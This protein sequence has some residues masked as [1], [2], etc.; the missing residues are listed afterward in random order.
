AR[1]AA[2]DAKP[3]VQAWNNGSRDAVSSV[4]RSFGTVRSLVVGAYAEASD[5]LH[6]LFDCVV[7]SASK[8]H[9]RR[10]GA[11]SA[12]EARSYFATTLRRAWGVHFAREFARHRIRRVAE[13]RWEMAVRDFGQ[14]VD[15]C[16]RIKEVL[17]NYEEGSLLKEMV[18][19]ADDAGASV[20][21]VL[22]DLRTHGSSELALPGTA[23]F[24]GPALVTHNDA[25]FADSDLESIQQI[26]G[27][28][29]AGS[30]STKT[31]RFGVGF[32]SC[33]HATDLPSFLSRDFLVVLDPHCAH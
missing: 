25:V 22:L 6:Q 5:D 15:V 21:D 18:Q 8:Q 2:L 3:H 13:P 20:F 7:E 30:R 4:L 23:A 14:K 12:K 29:K 24:Q 31:G 10:I 26:G 27:S 33:Y 17:K 32:C 1:A 28:Q 19:N 9:W 11:R 16:R